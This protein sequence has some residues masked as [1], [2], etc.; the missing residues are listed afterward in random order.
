MFLIPRPLLESAGLWN[1]NLSQI[2]DF[3]FFPRVLLKANEVLFT[4]E[5]VVYYRSGIAASLSGSLSRP[6]LLSA[7]TSLELTT[8]LLLQHEDSDRV[9]S[10]LFLL[11]DMWRHIFYLDDMSLYRRTLLQMKRL[12][13]YSNKYNVK[14][15]LLVKLIGWKFEKRIKKLIK[16]S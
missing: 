10:V 9:R 12:G 14:N 16:R 6:R 1:E 3:E 2:N 5:A 11:W 15:S 8:T 13:R 4:E 7:Y